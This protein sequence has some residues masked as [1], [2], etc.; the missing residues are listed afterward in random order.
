VY[1]YDRRELEDLFKALTAMPEI[2]SAHKA[3]K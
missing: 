3:T 1:V 2:V